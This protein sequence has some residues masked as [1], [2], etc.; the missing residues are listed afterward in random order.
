M[1]A[2]VEEGRGL[3]R[4]G[5][6][7]EENAGARELQAKRR[8]AHGAVPGRGGRMIASATSGGKQRFEHHETRF[9]SSG[10]SICGRRDGPIRKKIIGHGMMSVFWKRFNAGNVLLD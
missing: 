5:E 8:A 2:K 7:S 3:T 10:T 9:N 6:A 1:A 4:L